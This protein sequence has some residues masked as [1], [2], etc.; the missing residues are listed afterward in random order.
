MSQCDSYYIGLMSGT[1]IDNI[2]AAIVSFDN[3]T[4]TIVN[5]YS[6]PVSGQLKQ[7]ILDL[8]LPGDNEIERM[9]SLDQ[10]LGKAFAKAALAVCKKANIAPSNISGIGSHGQTIRHY[11]KTDDQLGYSLQIGDPNIIAN[12]TAIT[13]V[14]DFRRRDI[15]ANGHGAPLA[16]AF[17]Q[18][19]FSAPDKTRIIVNLGGI[20]N[21]SYLPPQ[22]KIIGFDSGPAN[23]LMDSWCEKHR[24]Q[25]YDHD[26]Q[27]AQ[28]G[29]CHAELLGIL[30]KHP[31]FLA[32]YPK[33]TGRETFNIQWLEESL[34]RVTIKP[35]NADI[36][37]TLLELTATTIAQA[38][39]QVDTQAAAQVFSCGG[40]SK[41]T[42]LM[43]RLSESIAPRSLATTTVLGIDS[44]WVECAAF[45]WMAKQTLS[46]NTSNLPEVTGANK[47][48]IL[49][50]IYWG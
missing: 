36:Q 21:I 17:H 38:I 13:T 26:G 30:L 50:G 7:A 44:D 10:Q 3:D 6:L 47:P 11:P 1:S 41:N 45:A 35:S 9:S 4:P 23:M 43:Q 22:G 34:A 39:E 8:A 25:A 2:D 12:E 37:A 49:G 48:V 24:G 33:S 5:T 28:S 46:H 32:P 29:Q 40:G 15:A 14:A 19:A 31:Y 16:P 42:A 18:M 27:W 20:A